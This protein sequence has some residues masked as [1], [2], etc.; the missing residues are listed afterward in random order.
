MD[1][2]ELGLLAVDKL[3]LLEGDMEI[4]EGLEVR[5]VAVLLFPTQA[6]CI[7][8]LLKN[9]ERLEEAVAVAVSAGDSRSTLRDC[10][11]RKKRKTWRNE[12][13]PTEQSGKVPFAPDL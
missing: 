13:G 8:V 12:W 11:S 6:L 10:R 7:Q 9:E 4:A 1:S 3:L 5:D 2:M